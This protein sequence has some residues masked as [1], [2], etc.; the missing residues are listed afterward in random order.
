[1]RRLKNILIVGLVL[2]VIIVGGFLAWLPGHYVV[3]IVMYHQVEEIAQPQP[4]WVSPQNF[5]RQMAYIKNHG[6]DVI[7]LDELVKATKAGKSLPRKTV[8]ITFDDGYENNYTAAFDILKK[9]GFPATIFVPSDKVNQ[10]GYLNWNQIKDMV[11]GGITIGSH[12]RTEAYLPDLSLAQQ[13]DEIQE[14]KRILEEN[15]GVSIDYF[16]YPIGG[17]SDQ[18][19]GIVQEAGYKAA[20]A[21]NRGY[22]RF[23]KDVFELNRVRFSDKDNRNDYLWMKLSGYYNLFRKAKN[24]Y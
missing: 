18:I 21:T 2:F 24:P 23:N 9:Y 8:V 4:N 3:P 10:P 20:C 11:A 5:E 22:D 15:L 1:M 19:K 16:C 7:R 17:F 13:K 14:S 12:T 6:Y